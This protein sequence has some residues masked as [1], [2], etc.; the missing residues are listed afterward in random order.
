MLFVLNSTLPPQLHTSLQSPSPLSSISASPPSE[1]NAS[2][3]PPPE[4]SHSLSLSIPA[5]HHVTAPSHT[6]PSDPRQSRT[7]HSGVTPLDPEGDGEDGRDDE[8]A[9]VDASSRAKSRDVS[10]GE[11]MRMC[12]CCFSPKLVEEFGTYS[13][14]GRIYQTCIECRETEEGNLAGLRRNWK[15]ISAARCAYFPS[16]PSSHLSH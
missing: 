8:E 6:H 5:H 14:E 10:K 9:V 1:P 7:L 12:T 3:L 4:T 16:S 11:M 2:D 13:K 15:T